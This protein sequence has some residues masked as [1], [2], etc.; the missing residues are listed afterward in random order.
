MYTK[1]L[2]Y[3]DPDG[4]VESTTYLNFSNCTNWGIRVDVS[5]PSTGCSS[6]ATGRTSGVAGLIASAARDAGL[7]LSAEELAQLIRRTADDI[8]TDADPLRYPT[9]KGWDARTGYGRVNVYRALVAVQQG[10]IP[11]EAEIL[12]PHWY[13]LVDPRSE[14]R[15]QVQLRVAAPRAGGLSWELAAAAGGNVTDAD[16]VTVA[17]GRGDASEQRPTVE[18]DWADL[19]ARTPSRNDAPQWHYAR[20]LRLT[21]WDDAG[22]VAEARKVVFILVDRDMRPGFPR[23]LDGSL[24]SSP[25]LADLDGDGRLEIVQATASGSL[26][27]IRGDGSD[28]DGFPVRLPARIYGPRSG[29]LSGGYTS[30]VGTPAVADIDGDGASEIVVADLEGFISVFAADGQMRPG[31]PREFPRDELPAAR[32]NRRVEDGFFAS[33][34]LHD[35]NGDGTMEIVVPGMDGRL[36]AYTAAGSPVAGFPVALS[37]PSSGGFTERIVS[38]PAIGDIDGDSAP[39]IVVGSK[40]DCGQRERR[41][42]HCDCTYLRC[43]P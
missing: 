2:M 10:R 25:K 3:D 36:Y 16:F 34:V 11:P 13:A 31:W 38:T 1:A 33:P 17:T 6:G 15:G 35:L 27:A 21:V 7:E 12:T 9:H 37:D 32:P 30:L 29:T 18:L 5:H 14:P 22:N 24:E 23:R 41:C 8:D 43:T 4:P 28:A 19:A 42:P 26:Y 39:E 40:R 20:T